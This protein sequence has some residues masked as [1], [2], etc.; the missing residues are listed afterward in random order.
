MTFVPQFIEP[1][2]RRV[3]KKAYGQAVRA[4]RNVCVASTTRRSGDGQH[5]LKSRASHLY[6]EAKVD[7]QNKT[8]VSIAPQA[9]IRIPNIITSNVVPL[10]A[11]A[12]AAVVCLVW[13]NSPNAVKRR[14]RK[15]GNTSSTEK[16]LKANTATG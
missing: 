7:T 12:S 10:A 11:A 14:E 6:D 15:R 16:L 1:Q 5:D 2:A 4:R 13:A 3:Y 8:V 9:P